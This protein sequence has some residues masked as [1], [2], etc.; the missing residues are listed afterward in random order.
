MLEVELKVRVPAHDPIRKR[1]T[2]QKAVSCGRLHEHDIYYNAPHRDF[3]KTD[4]A[5][6][7]RYTDDHAVVTYKGPKIKKFGLKA[8]EE[9]NFAVESGTAFETMLVRLG[10]TK[11]TEVNKWRE[12]YKLGTASISLDTVDELGTFAEI[13]VIIEDENSDPSAQIDKIAKEIGA[14]GDPILASYLELLLEK[15]GGT[16]H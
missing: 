14:V 5:V 13:E 12:N 1:L 16:G 10:F 9:L 15:R 6:R 4:E 8:R 2:S 3:G 11:T 7:V